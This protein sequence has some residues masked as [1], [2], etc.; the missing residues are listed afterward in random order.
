MK[1]S[2]ACIAIV[3]DY[4]TDTRLLLFDR[5]YGLYTAVYAHPRSVLCRGSV[6]TYQCDNIGALWRIIYPRITAQPS[7]WA[8]T[9]IWFLHHVIDVLR[10]TL[11]YRQPEPHIFQ[12]LSHMYDAIHARHDRAHVVF[13]VR[14]FFL[15]GIQPENILHLESL[16]EHVAERTFVQ[17][18]DDHTYT[19]YELYTWVKHCVREC[20][21]YNVLQTKQFYEV[22]RI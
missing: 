17:L 2:M 14:L 4:L 13:L 12:L 9:N 16:M 19:T 8:Y 7:T 3:L 22:Q 20:E 18:L 1:V 5:D 11:C 6:I 10:V 21:E 15:L